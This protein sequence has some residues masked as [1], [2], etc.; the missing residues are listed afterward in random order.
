MGHISMSGDDGA[1][2]GLATLGIG[3]KMF[4]HVN[5]SNPAH[6]PDSCERRRLEDAGW[7]IPTAGE[8]VAL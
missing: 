1:I 6:L 7:K 3:R 5:N 4:V 2:E 8:E